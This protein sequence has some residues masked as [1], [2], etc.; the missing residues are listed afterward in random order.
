LSALNE[1]EGMRV[2]LK[3]QNRITEF[4]RFAKELTSKISKDK[5]VVGIVLLGGVVRGFADKFSDLDITVFLDKKD[6]GLCRKIRNIGS[7]MA[8]S[9]NVDLDLMVHYLGDLRKW[10]MKE[11][12]LK[13]EYSNAKI[14]LD[15]KGDVKR[16]LRGKLRPPKDFWIRR[17]VVCGE[18][19]KWYCCPPEEGVGTISESWIERGDLASAHYCLNYSVDLLLRLLFAINREFV[20]APKWR[21]FYSY[22]LKW[23]PSDYS[24]LIQ[25][26]MITPRLS[27]GE[28]NRRL[29]AIRKIWHGI[30]AKIEEETGLTPKTIS[31]Y[32]VEKILQQT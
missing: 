9:H 20:P 5:N 6:D 30:A 16:V 7:Q 12:A 21:I 11:E 3:G 23:L 19:I 2:E 32:Y 29:T 10:K 14:V 17:I 8:K 25:E 4:R 1:D 26:A 31:K 18:Y 28:F 24:E 15:D 22:K 27:S 13:W